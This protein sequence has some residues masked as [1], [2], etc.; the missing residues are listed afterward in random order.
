MFAAMWINGK[1]HIVMI[2]AVQFAYILWEKRLI[3]GMRLLYVATIG[4]LGL[5]LFNHWYLEQFKYV[6]RLSQGASRS[7]Y[8]EFRIDYGRDDVIKL[9]I[10]AELHPD[11]I[12]ILEYRGQSMLF[13]A[14]AFIPRSF[15]PDKPYPPT[16]PI[17]TR[18]MLLPPCF[19]RDQSYGVG[20]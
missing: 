13:Y 2:V 16:N 12:S 17:R 15:F 8:T 1:R 7:R 20:E 19:C 5:A 9:A 10:Y 11:Q 3:R 4:I 18:N 14:T 6:G